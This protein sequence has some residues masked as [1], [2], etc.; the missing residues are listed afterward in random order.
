MFRFLLSR[1]WVLFALF[2]VLLGAACWRLGVWQFDRL[3]ER[4]ADNTIIERNLDAP[5]VPA[6]TVMDAAQPLPEQQQ[7]RKV[8]VTGTYDVA[9]QTLVRYQTRDGRPGVNVITPLHTEAGSTVLVDRGW[10]QVTND[11]TAPVA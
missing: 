5:P 3:E 7:W 9:E 4:R 1:R 10:M 11:P 6:T 2:V 8:T